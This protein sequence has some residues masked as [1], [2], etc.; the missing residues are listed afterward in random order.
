MNHSGKRD[1]PRSLPGTPVTRRGLDLLVD[2]AHAETRCRG[3]K[4]IKPR[5]FASAEIQRIFQL[6][7]CLQRSLSPGQKRPVFELHLDNAILNVWHYLFTAFHTSL[8][9]L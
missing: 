4:I 7:Q 3:S 8:A 6:L 5:L 9:I 2:I 1:E